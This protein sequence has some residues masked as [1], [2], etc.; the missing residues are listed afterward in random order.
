MCI[1]VEKRH[2]QCSH[3]KTFV[4]RKRCANA[5]RTGN[6]CSKSQCSFVEGE[7]ESLPLCLRCYRATEQGICESTDKLLDE[8]K[9]H[10]FRTK[11]QLE[12]PDLTLMERGQLRDL[13][14]EVEALRVENRRM[15]AMA[16]SQFRNSQGVWGDG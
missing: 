9:D 16:L 14:I 8:I 10:I 3:L 11:R 5:D 13:L 1:G 6:D 7:I 15:R 4:I 2:F 12:N